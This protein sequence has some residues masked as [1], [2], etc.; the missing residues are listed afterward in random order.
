MATALDLLK[1][2]KHLHDHG[3]FGQLQQIEFF[4]ALES[5]LS[6]PADPPKEEHKVPP[7]VHPKPAKRE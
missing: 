5:I 3:A 2:A 4:K 7:K 6:A 1:Q